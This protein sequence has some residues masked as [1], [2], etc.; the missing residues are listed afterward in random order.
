MCRTS[1]RW[2]HGAKRQ[3]TKI[4][5]MPSLRA[6]AAIQEW[7]RGKMPKQEVRVKGD[8]AAD[9]GL[10]KMIFYIGLH[11]LTLCKH[12][13]RS[14]VSVN[15]LRKRK[16]DFTVNNWVMDSGAFTEISTNGRFRNTVSEYAEQIDRWRAC[17]NME[18]AVAQDYMCEPFV[19]A[20]TGMTVKEHQR[21]TI[22]RYD[23]LVELSPVGVMPVLQGYM[24]EEYLTHLRQYGDR[25]KHGMRVGVGSICKRNSKPSDIAEVLGTIKAERPDIKLHGFGLKITALANAYILSLLESADSMAW[26]YRARRNG[27]NPNGLDEAANFCRQIKKIQGKKPHQFKII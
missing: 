24:P 27:G 8:K 19:L 6:E 16:S 9:A 21:L 5:R 23:E 14:F 17:G 2:G 11:V 22:E 7:T 10:V 1:R 13:D 3:R 26:S 4:Q 20:K 25:V 12:F 15:I 18:L